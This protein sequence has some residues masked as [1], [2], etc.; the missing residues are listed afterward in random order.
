MPNGEKALNDAFWKMATSVA[1][2][3]VLF[4]SGWVWNMEGRVKTLET[5]TE[6][7]MKANADAIAEIRGDVKE[8]LR[9]LRK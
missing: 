5:A 1:V 8:I 2:A 4:L 6:I 9:E 3:L 7:R